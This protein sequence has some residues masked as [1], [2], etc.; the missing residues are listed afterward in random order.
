MNEHAP[1]YRPYNDESRNYLYNLLFCDDPTLFAQRDGKAPSAPWAT[2]LAANPDARALQAIA[3][4]RHAEGRVRALA[5]NRL[6]GMRIEVTPRVLLGTV[7]EVG[8]AQGLD[9]LAAYIDGGVRYLNHS[10]AV[11]I[12]EGNPSPLIDGKVRAVIDAS[13]PIVERIGP[14]EERRRPPPQE[15]QARLSFLVSDGL[16]FGE[17]PFAT[18]AE[19]PMSLPLVRASLELLTAVVD[20]TAKNGQRAQ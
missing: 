5:Y 8:L 11:S 19:D 16:Y 4:D 2:V 1:Y 7:V 18:L 10:N 3:D 15:D 20:A 17:G 14:W 9:V 13:Q 6:R 12:V